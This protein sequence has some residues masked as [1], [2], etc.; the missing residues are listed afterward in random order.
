[1]ASSQVQQ[2]SV[3]FLKREGSASTLFDYSK[4][5]RFSQTK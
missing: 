1:M 3:P 4:M 2:D 5:K